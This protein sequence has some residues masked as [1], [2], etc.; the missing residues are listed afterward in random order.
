MM[1]Y[2]ENIGDRWP[3]SPRKGLARSVMEEELV[4]LGLH[5]LC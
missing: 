5:Q 4:P 3:S 2:L 1:V